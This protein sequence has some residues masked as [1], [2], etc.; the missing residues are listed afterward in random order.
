MHSLVHESY[1]DR[2]GA[3]RR[4]I[5][6]ACSASKTGT[7]PNTRI[8]RISTIRPTPT[9]N[10]YGRRASIHIHT[11]LHLGHFYKY[12]ITPSGTHPALRLP[13]PPLP[14]PTPNAPTRARTT[15]RAHASPAMPLGRADADAHAHAARM[16]TTPHPHPT[17]LGCP[18]AAVENAL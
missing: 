4:H 17:L 3:P 7:G 10:A 8:A 5:K 9:P 6:K 12:I 14:L 15:H 2:M 18:A 1:S 16:R 11:Y 13:A